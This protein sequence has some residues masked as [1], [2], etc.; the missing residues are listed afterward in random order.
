MVSGILLKAGLY[1]LIVLLLT[2]GR[3]DFYGVELI[4]VMLWIG[5]I[6]ALIGNLL[7]IF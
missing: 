2:M 5:A 6:T 4:N 3:Q 1:G 7:A